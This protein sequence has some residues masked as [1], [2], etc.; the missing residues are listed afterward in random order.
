MTNPF[1]L[2]K[3]SSF[4]LVAAASGLCFHGFQPSS[5]SAQPTPPDNQ[6][7]SVATTPSSDC[8]ARR[9]KLELRYLTDRLGDIDRGFTLIHLAFLQDAKDHWATPDV[10]KQ[11]AAIWKDVQGDDESRCFALLNTG[12]WTVREAL[13]EEPDKLDGPLYLPAI[14]EYVNE[15]DARF[16]AISR[17]YI[18]K[19]LNYKE[20][21]VA[22]SADAALAYPPHIGEEAK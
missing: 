11:R 20:L 9:T 3:A 18:D 8:E 1:S 13:K 5:S 22:E 15:A 14:R 19:I 6:A 7:R 16:R 17:R 4:L 2:G 21:G 10:W 12:K